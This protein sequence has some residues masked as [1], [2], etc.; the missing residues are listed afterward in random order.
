VNRTVERAEELLAD[1]IEKTGT[2][3]PLRAL[4]LADQDL[5][6]AL[7]SADLI[8][9][10]TSLGWQED[11]TPLDAELIPRSALV[12]DMVYRPTRLLREAAARG[13]STLDGRGMLVRQ[14]GLAFER[15][16]G[17][18]API[19]IMFAAFDQA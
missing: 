11:Q 13:A 17:Q 9:N 1:L 10:A 14:A 5:A 19:D 6:D 18:R 7:A 4:M 12:F 2:E 15:W 8:I 16:T 3:A